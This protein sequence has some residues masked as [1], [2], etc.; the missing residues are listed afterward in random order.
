MSDTVILGK[1]ISGSFKACLLYT[2]AD[3][4]VSLGQAFFSMEKADWEAMWWMKKMGWGLLQCGSVF[5]LIKAFYS[6]SSTKP[7]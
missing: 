2:M 3:I 5:I 4:C 7:A 1:T 6:K